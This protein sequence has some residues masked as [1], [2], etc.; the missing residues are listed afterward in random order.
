M[1]TE[2]ESL[3]DEHEQRGEV[4]A[5]EAL[6]PWNL[7]PVLDPRHS[8]RK[9]RRRSPSPEPPPAGR[10]GRPR[11]K[12]RGY[13]SGHEWTDGFRPS[14]PL[15]WQC[16]PKIRVSVR[17]YLWG[18]H[19]LGDDRNENPGTRIRDLG[20]RRSGASSAATAEA[21]GGGDVKNK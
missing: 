19:Y 5:I 10:L 13:R 12:E 3:R 4:E 7:K 11:F 17:L 8:G 9:P 14:T 16:A 18:I 15:P 2:I 21:V 1:E 20:V 6:L